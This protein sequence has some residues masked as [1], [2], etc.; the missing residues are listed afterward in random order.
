MSTCCNSVDNNK[1]DILYLRLE[2]KINELAEK[3]TKNN[4]DINV[5][6]SELCNSLKDNLGNSIRELVDT[7][8]NTGE[9][10][11]IVTDVVLQDIIQEIYKTNVYYDGIT[12]EKLR[13]TVSNTDYY[14]TTIPRLDSKGLPI[15]LRV[16]IADD[17]K[18]CNSLESTLDFASRKN[19]TVC[20]NAGV[21]NVDTNYPLGTL[22]KDGKALYT[23]NPTD[24]KY[25]FLGIKYDNT[26]KVYPRS[27]TAE[28]MIN[29]NVRDAI[30]IFNSLIIDG[31]EVSQTDERKDPRQS[32]GITPEGTINIITCDGR[33][34]DNEGMSYADLARL[35]KLHNSINAYILDGGGSASTVVK[36]IKQNA[37]VDFLTDDRKVNNFLYVARPTNTTPDNNA[38]ND[39]GAVKQELL[40]K[41]INKL[42]FTKG[43]LRLRGPENYFAPGIEMFVNNEASR[44]S[45]LGLSF[46]KD[47]VRNTYLYWG[48]KAE[49]TEKTNL[50]RIYN[51][52]VWVQL[53]NGTS[54]ERPNGVLGLC[55]FDTTL[56]KPIWYNGTNWIDST[57][58][59]V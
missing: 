38:N 25:Q 49:A 28:A 34:I 9:F 57:G 15:E 20:I 45:K 23:L 26:L 35:H 56:N 47:N 16:G 54:G 27:T 4:I 58:A 37:N 44:R 40:E 21:Y 24:E 30:C 32:I 10:S 53:Y 3:F 42:D 13:D 1:D 52:G 5:S 11:N 22:I 55:Y 8:V 33:M 29:D 59:T 48:L 19:A 39:I 36:G 50:F 51:Q 2:E 14:L 43:Y 41:I 12:T 7:M 31:A 6:L 17:N 46:D 18:N